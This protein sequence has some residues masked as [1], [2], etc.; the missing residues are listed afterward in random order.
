MQMTRLST[1]ARFWHWRLGLCLLVF[2]CPL[3]VHAASLSTQDKQAIT[4]LSQSRGHQPADVNRLIDRVERAADQGLPTKPMVNKIKEGL[5]KGVPPGRIDPVV[6]GLI[7]NFETAR[8]V[9]GEFSQSSSGAKGGQPSPRALEVLAESLNRGATPEEVRALGKAIGRGK[10]KNSSESIAF[11]A[12]GLALAKEGGLSGKDSMPLVEEALRQ[13]FLPKDILELGREIKKRGRELRS[14]PDR[15]KKIRDAVKQG[16]RADRI[17]RDRSKKGSGKNRGGEVRSDR[18]QEE[19]N[20]PEKI[21]ENRSGGDRV[22]P[23]RMDRRGG[24]RRDRIETPRD[25]G[26]DNSGR[27]RG[28]RGR[29]D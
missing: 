11:G 2:V 29:S 14:D 18:K 13:D 12:K 7:R 5:A 21:R 26:R 24:G 23:D 27:G 16:D 9:L 3:W 25:R 4:K 20:R 10:G 15:L 17:F 6:K 1:L 8:S 19:K 28:G 22:R